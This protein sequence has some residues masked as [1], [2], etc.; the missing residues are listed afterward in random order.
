MNT[1]INET[2]RLLPENSCN[3]Q[4][5]GSSKQTGPCGVDNLRNTDGDQDAKIV[6]SNYQVEDETSQ[7][8]AVTIFS[9]W[10][11]LMG[12]SLLSMPW[13]FQQAG[14]AQGIIVQV[15]MCGLAVYTAYLLLIASEKLTDPVTKKAPEYTEMCRNL[16]GRWAEWLNI[17][18]STVILASALIVYWILM[19]ELLYNAVNS[20]YYFAGGLNN[21]HHS[22]VTNLTGEFDNERC[23]VQEKTFSWWNKNLTVPL[24]F[25]PIFLPILLL[26]K[27]SFFAK[28]GALGALSVFA[29][30]S[31]VFVKYVQWGWNADFANTKNKHYI[32]QILGSFPSLSGLLGMAYFIHNSVT[33]IF[34]HNRNQGNNV[35]D[36][37]IAYMLVLITY[38]FIGL[39]VY[40]TFPLQKSCI[41][42]N[43]LENL[44]WNDYLSLA[45]Q[46]L[47]FLRMVTVYPIVAY[48]LRV[49]IFAA[50]VGNEY[51]GKFYVF[52]FN[53]I[54]MAA[55]VL[56]AIFYPNIGDIIRYAGAFC[57]MALM[58]ILP[59]AI[60]VILLRRDQSL[61]K[62]SCFIHFLI[63]VVGVINFVAQFTL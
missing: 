17:L 41:K 59:C 24:L 62:V 8:S 60:H 37:K 19:V 23:M 3:Q 29:L 15:V 63:A 20:V 9:F 30:M 11:M 36:L 26:K 6:N 27:M 7:N 42:Q 54:I 38:M 40:L 5:Y 10:N 46:V 18:A 57:A 56:C 4:L 43:F 1:D 35:R 49:Q 58:F 2:A 39:G 48:I 52:V 61:S 16:V 45:V 21:I 55:C 50:L 44:P 47:L 13:A 32:P 34:K 51:P 28:L 33:T 14:M 31:I 25:I 22:N 53:I 12:T